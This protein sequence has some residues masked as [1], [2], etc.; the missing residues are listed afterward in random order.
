MSKLARTITAIVALLAVGLTPTIA[1]AA[2]NNPVPVGGRQTIWAVPAFPHSAAGTRSPG[3]L[4]EDVAFAGNALTGTLVVPTLTSQNSVGSEHACESDAAC[5]TSDYSLVRANGMFPVCQS[6]EQ[7]PC[8]LSMEYSSGVSDYRSAVFSGVLD[9]SPTA[10]ELS[11]I[12]PQAGQTLVK[13]VMHLGWGSNKLGIPASAAGPLLFHLPGVTNGAG[14]DTF[15]VQASFSYNGTLGPSGI[16]MGDFGGFKLSVVPVKNDAAQPSSIRVSEWLDSKGATHVSAGGS[17]SYLPSESP[18]VSQEGRGFSASFP[19]DL[20]LR[21]KLRLPSSLGGWLQGRADNPDITLERNTDSSN[22]LTLEANPTAVPVTGAEFG[23]NDPVLEQIHDLIGL[24]SEWVSSARSRAAAGASGFGLI[25]FPNSLALARLVDLEPYLGSTAKGST[26]IWEF[27][28]LASSNLCMTDNRSLQGVLTTNAMV[29]QPELP[30]L[31][32]GQLTYKVAGLHF[33]SQ[34]NVFQGTYS[35]IMKDSVARC[36]Y[37]FKGAGPISGT[38][39]VTSSDGAENV[40]YTNVTDD[41]QWL[42]LTAH[43]FTFSNPTISAKL[44][45]AGATTDAPA[46][47]SGAS[48]GA[49]ASVIKSI[50]CAKGKLTK[51]VTGS[52]AKCPTGWKKK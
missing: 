5:V 52:S 12:A 46:T 7:G 15:M 27:Q 37:G 17:G 13:T 32:N 18:Y 45:Q 11:L 28:S 1:S 40:A 4:Y 48:A 42:K 30:M 3:S 47:G 36:L 9:E 35:F 23:I 39:T 31:Q 29:Y 49:S 41:G 25:E 16:V 10:S 50:T 2:D 22:L 26:S 19:P 43:G 51:K 6:M 34:G 38:V 33:D 8:L 14:V 44:T 21:L 24:S 20:K